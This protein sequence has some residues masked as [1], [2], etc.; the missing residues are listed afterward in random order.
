VVQ[1]ANIHQ[2]EDIGVLVVHQTT[3]LNMVATETRKASLLE[4]EVVIRDQASSRDQVSSRDLDLIPIHLKV[5]HF[6]K[7]KVTDT[8]AIL[9][10]SMV[11]IKA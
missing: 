5:I 2:V 11:Q 8:K 6:F 10:I 4:A 7:V 9:L 3:H 1:K